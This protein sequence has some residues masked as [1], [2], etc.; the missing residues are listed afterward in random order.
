MKPFDGP[1][2]SGGNVLAHALPHPNGNVHFDDDETYTVN[3]TSGKIP[4]LNLYCQ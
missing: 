2:Y 3:D 4:K 1:S